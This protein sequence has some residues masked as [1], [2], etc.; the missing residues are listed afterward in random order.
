MENEEEED[1]DDYVENGRGMQQQQ[2]E[3]GRNTTLEEEDASSSKNCITRVFSAILCIFPKVE[4]LP[5][6]TFS[7]LTLWSAMP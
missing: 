2:S 4:P 7:I 1:D 6:G 5:W 3:E